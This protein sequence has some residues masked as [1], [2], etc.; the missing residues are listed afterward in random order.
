MYTFIA[1]QLYD[2]QNNKNSLI[3]AF[4]MMDKDGD[5]VIEAEEL[6]ELFMNEAGSSLSREEIQRIVQMVDT[7]GSGRIDFTEFMVAATNED[8]MLK[9][10]ELE[11]AFNYLDSDHSGYITF[12]EVVAFLDGTDETKEEIMAMFEEVD[13]NGDGHITKN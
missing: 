1:S 7:N 2:G 4:K 11:C 13:D 3:N 9:E 6:E 12:E 10:K 8:D 5:G